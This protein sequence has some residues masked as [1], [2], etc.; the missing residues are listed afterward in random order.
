MLT[1]NGQKRQQLF[2]AQ[3]LQ[4]LG[5]SDRRNRFFI[6]WNAPIGQ[7]C[8]ACAAGRAVVAGVQDHRVLD[9]HLAKLE[10]HAGRSRAA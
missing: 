4:R 3:S 5:V 1:A 9:R 6:K 10:R 8:T 2:T 7:Q